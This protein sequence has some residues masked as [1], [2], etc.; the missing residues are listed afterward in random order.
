[1]IDNLPFTLEDILTTKI[2]ENL[3]SK[4]M[5][6]EFK[7]IHDQHHSITGVV[8]VELES[9]DKK[10]IFFKKHTPVPSETSSSTEPPV[11]L[12]RREGSVL[13]ILYHNINRTIAPRLLGRIT[14]INEGDFLLLTEYL[15]ENS[16]KKRFLG[17]DRKIQTSS[18]EERPELERQKLISLRE[19]VRLIAKFNGLCRAHENQIPPYFHT[20]SGTAEEAYREKQR[21]RKLRTFNYLLRS[22]HYKELG[23][24]EFQES[25]GEKG[26]FFDAN[27][28]DQY[29][30]HIRKSKKVDLPEKL[31]EIFRLQ[32]AIKT[33]IR[34]QIG[35]CRLDH[36]IDGKF[37]DLEDF[38]YYDWCQDIVTY[39]SEEIAA[40]PVNELP[41]LL[42]YYL[43]YER[44]YGSKSHDYQLRELKE[45]DG[46]DPHDIK[47]L[48]SQRV[49]T[50]DFAD[51][52]IGYLSGVLIENDIILDGVRKKY[53]PERLQEMHPG[54]S[55]EEIH[56][57]K[58][59][60][61]EKLYDSF[62]QSFGEPEILS[63]C[64][65][66][67]EVKQYFFH[68][69]KLLQDLGLVKI[70]NLNVLSDGSQWD[71]FFKR[72]T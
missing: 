2:E 33:K 19:D 35:D 44:A 52:V 36:N 8:T 26:R 54:R 9:G 42:A 29:L 64:S 56:R 10:D 66:G 63:Y 61:V 18:E 50:T 31:K 40:P 72:K 45:L 62:T 16:A 12:H 67:R 28:V 70:E 6:M 20:F 60:H 69:G 41:G 30:V 37:C 46:E 5:G 14:R 65:N 1:M 47:R 3:K 4:V 49:S 51:F 27:K 15:G 58:M 55:L 17:I 13:H 34:P 68:L 71:L 53:S 59:E 22:I 39:T 32:E 11:L 25:D 43:V 23:G 7:E 38:G 21:L 57:A 48:L 24:R